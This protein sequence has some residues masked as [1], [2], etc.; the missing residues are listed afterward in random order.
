MASKAFRQALFR[1]SDRPFSSPLLRRLEEGFSWGK[2]GARRRAKISVRKK[3][4]F[5]TCE[6]K[7]PFA[8]RFFSL[9]TQG[10]FP[11]Y[12]GDFSFGGKSISPGRKTSFPSKE[13]RAPFGRKNASFRRAKNFR[14]EG[15]K[16]PYIRK[17]ISA[18]TKKY[19]RIC[20][21]LFSCAQKFFALRKELFCHPKNEGLPPE[22]RAI[23]TPKEGRSE[24]LWRRKTPIS[25]YFTRGLDAL[26]LRP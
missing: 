12:G 1:P 2:K 13:K 24:A 17:F 20:G 10:F 3:I 18:Y 21:N 23:G 6:K 22:R 19:F 15:R 25:R 9:R 11:S 14:A 26:P 8:R 7:S 5:R 4:Y 16:F